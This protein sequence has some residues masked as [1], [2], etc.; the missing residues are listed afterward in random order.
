MHAARHNLWQSAIAFVVV[1]THGRNCGISNANCNACIAAVPR[2][3]TPQRQTMAT[4]ERDWT[5]TLRAFVRGRGHAREDEGARR[6]HTNVL[7]QL[8]AHRRVCAA[9]EEAKVRRH[10]VEIYQQ[11]QERLAAT[12]PAATAIPRFYFHVGA[13]LAG[14]HPPA[15]PP[16]RRKRRP[17]RSS[18]CIISR[19]PIFLSASTMSC[20]MIGC[21]P[22]C[23]CASALRGRQSAGARRTWRS[24][25]RGWKISGTGRRSGSGALTM[26]SSRSWAVCCPRASP[27][28]SGPKCS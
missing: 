23:W 1:V 16:S 9:A 20:L 27:L 15:H 22:P 24:W 21:V 19:A 5:D 2:L 3:V 17:R 14:L 25:Q 13:C 7:R 28:C 6:L 4:T 11:R 12:R 8:A 18:G 26:I 10:M